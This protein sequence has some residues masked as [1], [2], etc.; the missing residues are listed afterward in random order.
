MTFY[1][2]QTKVRNPV[3]TE[4]AMNSVFDLLMISND[5]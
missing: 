5:L 1:A 3:N 4:A 2:Y